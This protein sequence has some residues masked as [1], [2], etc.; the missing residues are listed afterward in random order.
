M[1]GVRWLLRSE[2]LCFCAVHEV[3]VAVLLRWDRRWENVG[4]GL[5]EV[6]VTEEVGRRSR[7]RAFRFSES[8]SEGFS[9]S[10]P[11]PG[12]VDRARNDAGPGRANRSEGLGAGLGRALSIT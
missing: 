11:S 7:V 9:F 12:G 10:T 8:A 3:R 6:A 2:W 5:Q 1:G 4:E